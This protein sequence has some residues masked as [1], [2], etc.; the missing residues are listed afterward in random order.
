MLNVSAN[1]GAQSIIFISSWPAT[2]CPAGPAVT[3]RG[4]VSRDH[5]WS[6][7]SMT[8][9]R[10]GR[11]PHSQT[12]KSETKLN[13]HYAARC[14]ARGQINRAFQI[15]YTMRIRTSRAHVAHAQSSVFPQIR[16]HPL[17]PSFS[18]RFQRRG[19]EM[20]HDGPPAAVAR[21]PETPGHGE[22]HSS[23]SAARW[24]GTRRRQRWRRVGLTA[25]RLSGP[26]ALAGRRHRR[27]RSGQWTVVFRVMRLWRKGICMN[28]YAVHSC[29]FCQSPP[30]ETARQTADEN[31]ARQ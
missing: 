21:S 20:R 16:S 7:G 6:A 2:D 27:L 24:A 15:N 10:T 18:L 13:M 17:C 28:V 8:S 12:P 3:R 23:T 29:V 22:W 5:Q 25:P 30:C 9:H 26:T 19:P 31:S 1:S 14:H 4:R 11:T